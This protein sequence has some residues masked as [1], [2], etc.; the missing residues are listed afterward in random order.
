M[1]ARSSRDRARSEKKM[2]YLSQRAAKQIT[3]ALKN[4]L[5]REFGETTLLSNCQEAIAEGF[6]FNSAHEMFIRTPTEVTWNAMWCIN[7]L[8]D[9]GHVSSMAVA[10]S[11]VELLE[12]RFRILSG[13]PTDGAPG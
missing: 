5:R 13:R 7:C 2:T 10:A 1:R 6:D 9:A 8:V 12:R 4:V 11:A 3:V